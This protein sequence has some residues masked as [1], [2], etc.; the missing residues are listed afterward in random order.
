MTQVTALRRFWR[1]RGVV[2]EVRSAP[3][4][5]PARILAMA[6]AYRRADELGGAEFRRA[7][8]GLAEYAA[9]LAA[10]QAEHAGLRAAFRAVPPLLRVG[11]VGRLVRGC[12][13]AHTAASGAAD[14]FARRCGDL[15]GRARI[16]VGVEAG[17][18]V[19]E[20]A[21]LASAAARGY[22]SGVL[23]LRHLRLA[24]ERLAGSA[25][26][27][28]LLD[29]AASD[30]ERAWLVKAMAAGDTGLAEF[31]A[32]IRGR[33][34]DWLAERLTLVDRHAPGTQSRLGAAVRQHEPTTCGTTCLIVARAEWDPRYALALTSAEFATAFRAARAAVHAETNR[35]YPRF[36]GT[37]PH[38]MARWL[39]RH[40]GVR[41]RWRAVD[42]T[43]A[44]D[45]SR[46]LRDVLAAVDAG[47][48]VPVL[49]G[50]VVPR[51]YVL[52]VGHHDGSVLVFEPSAGRTVVVPDRAF[53]D[54]DLRGALG[55][56][57]LQAVV[58][59]DDQ[60]GQPLSA[61][62]SAD[63]SK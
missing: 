8:A 22:D 24:G 25:E 56:P 60:A 54:G 37:S 63:G 18:P 50:A 62:M 30:L 21:E 26:A 52:V 42:D 32:A 55:F 53:L 29:R 61:G 38:G 28:A 36:A 11:A 20:A 7:A 5:D 44:R 13:Q 58:L 23:G 3:A 14:L 9:V 15:A 41:H 1:L 39:T 12:V 43:D 47:D 45:V 2:G 48:P 57:H 35:W 31:A 27:R 51:H 16:A 6:Q 19:A 46:A 40:L 59:P 17:L 34:A 4:G 10:A 33:P 49:V